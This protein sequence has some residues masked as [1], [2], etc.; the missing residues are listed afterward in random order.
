MEFRKLRRMGGGDSAGVTL[1]KE[2]LRDIGFVTEGE[3][4]EGYARI[5]R[6]GDLEFRIKL[7]R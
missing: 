6:V 3:V 2:D 7:V 1:P 4:K 5:E